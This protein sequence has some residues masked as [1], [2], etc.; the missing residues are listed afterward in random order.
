MLHSCKEIRSVTSPLQIYT[1]ENTIQTGEWVC[2]G[3]NKEKPDF[4]T[5]DSE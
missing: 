1:T 5:Y 4:N 2:N 3:T